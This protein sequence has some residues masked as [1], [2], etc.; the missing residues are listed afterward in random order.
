V[1]G[2]TLTTAAI[3]LRSTPYGESDRVVSLLGRTTGRI[4]AL[5]RGARKSQRRF[6]GMGLGALGEASF[7]ERA[8]ADLAWLERFEVIEGRLGLGTDLGRTAQAGYVSELCDKLCAP[9]QPE[10]QVFDWLN[11]F[12]G[13][14]E[15]SGASSE[16]LRIFELGLLQ[17]LGL[18]PAFDSCVGCSRAD[19]GQETV[20]LQPDRGGVL[21]DRCAHRGTPLSPPV[22]RA[23]VSLS[24]LDLDQAAE[25][26]IDR[27]INAACRHAIFELLSNHLP[28]PLKSLEFVEKLGG[29]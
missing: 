27:D 8:G 4:G 3:L 10:V 12:L 13:L 11:H 1:A 14:L 15:S 16:R 26:R 20:R 5:A 7:R 9:H 25:I 17:R 2:E 24:G 6:V 18:G 22:R 23:L 19:L 21:C 29:L 28:G